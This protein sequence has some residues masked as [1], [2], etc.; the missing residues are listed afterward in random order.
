MH[1]VRFTCQP[2]CT[3]C[4]EVKGFV[5]ITEQ[6]LQNAAKYLNMSAVD[7]EARYVY[8]TKGL[9][10]LRKPPNSQCHFLN[11]RG[12]GIHPAKPT[13]CRMFPFWPELV[14]RP[15]N[16]KETAKYCPGIGHGPLIQI[17]TALEMAHEMR[18]AYPFMYE[19]DKPL[20]G[21]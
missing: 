21:A 10:R 20:T 8:R 16:W 3:I 6:D 9:L 12:C 7:F 17:G 19:H 4:C 2:N 14:E 11:E 5:Y 1:G 15:A 18:E 13:Q